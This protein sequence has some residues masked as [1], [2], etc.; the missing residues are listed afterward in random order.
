M[1]HFKSLLVALMLI[2]GATSFVNAQDAA[3]KMAHI[4]TQKLVE[5]M[6]SMIAAQNQL[7]KLQQTYDTEIQTMAKEL[8]AKITQYDN[9]AAS[10]TDEENGKRIAE[11]QGMQQKIQEYQ[12]NALKD[13]QEKEIELMQ[14]LLDN[15]RQAIQKV[16]RAKGYQYVVDCATGNGMIL[17]DGFDLL[18][19]VKSEM[20]I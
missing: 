6:P 15:A 12:Q 5:A 9:E 10:K 20:G 19:D 8:Q 7:K 16:A 2:F 1:K 3:A 4:D 13:L 11:V 17:C 14:P 18:G